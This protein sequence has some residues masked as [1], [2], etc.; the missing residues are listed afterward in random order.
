MFYLH[1]FSSFPIISITARMSFSEYLFNYLLLLT[2]R[3][4]CMSPSR[5]ILLLFF[6]EVTL[7]FLSI[8]NFHVPFLVIPHKDKYFYW[9][10]QHCTP[11]AHAE[12]T[13]WNSLCGC[14]LNVY[15]SVPAPDTY[16]MQ[17]EV[18]SDFML[19]YS[20]RTLQS[21]Q[22]HSRLS[23]YFCLKLGKMKE[24]GMEERK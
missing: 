15:C 5:C 21:C 6:M 11:L 17:A 10:S 12:L 8:P 22:T 16:C 4:L 13:F 23:V 19:H 3:S 9:I 24:G 18:T 2:I 14:L 7:T 20:S 1:T